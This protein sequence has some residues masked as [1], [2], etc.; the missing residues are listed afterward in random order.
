[1]DMEEAREAVVR[2]IG[3]AVIQLL[4]EG[5]ALTKEGIAEMV[6]MLA[7]D[8]PDLAVEFALGMLR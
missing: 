5:R 2:V 4:A 8:E 3:E 7:G 6:S 1:M